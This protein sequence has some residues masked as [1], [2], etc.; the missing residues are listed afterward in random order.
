MSTPVHDGRVLVVAHGTEVRDG[1]ALEPEAVATV[2]TDF[3]ERIGGTDF[4]TELARRFYALVAEDD[5]LSPLFPRRDW[6]A[7]ARGLA[8]HFVRIYGHN[9]LTA[10]WDPDLHRRHAHRIITREQRLR[11]LELMSC[12]GHSLEPPQDQLDQFLAIM[13]IASGEMMAAS[14]GAA[15]ARRESFH[16]DGSP[17]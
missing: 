2:V 17:R 11:W 5:V 15:L 10:A 14:R 1:E 8:A 6:A 4:F 9:D 7:Q 13:K 16:W 3:Y 12:A